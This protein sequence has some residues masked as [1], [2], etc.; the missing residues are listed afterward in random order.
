MARLTLL[1]QTTCSHEALPFASILRQWPSRTSWLRGPGV[2]PPSLPIPG[3][4]E[5][6]I[7]HGLPKSV[8]A[9]IERFT[10]DIVHMS[11][12]DLLG[13]GAQKFARRFGVPIVA[14]LHTCFSGR[15]HS[16]TRT[17]SRADTPR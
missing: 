4:S 2:G 6:R 15:R 1:L 10:P 12:R 13:T 17:F 9:D 14:S 16:L 7:A 3:R 11:A 8:R 5:F